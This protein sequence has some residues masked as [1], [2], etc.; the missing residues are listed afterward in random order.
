MMKTN[1]K[2]TYLVVVAHPDDEVL[3]AGATIKKLTQTGHRVAVAILSSTVEERSG[4]SN[5]LKQEIEEVRKSL[6]VEKYYLGVFPNIKMNTVPHI[7]LVKYIEQCIADFEADAIITHSSS[8]TNDDHIHTSKATQAA[9]RFFQRKEGVKSLKKLM[10][11]EVPSSTDWSFDNSLNHFSPNYF[12]EIGT[13]GVESKIKALNL[14]S[15]AMRQYPH[16][17]SAESIRALAIYRGSCAGCDMAEA[18][19]CVYS[20]ERGKN[21]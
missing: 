3:G 15:G 18:F 13:G 10:Y 12:V 21:V 1:D 9:S 14:Y 5:F 20:C 16:P 6:G 4:R 19:E 7:D 11:M 2:E 17:R 8:E